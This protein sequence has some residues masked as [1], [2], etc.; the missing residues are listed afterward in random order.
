M[1][2]S[3]ACIMCTTWAHGAS[4]PLGLEL[5]MVLSC[6]VVIG[7]EPGPSARALSALTLQPTAA[8]CPAIAVCKALYLDLF[9]CYS[10][11]YLGSLVD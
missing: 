11:G 7:I 10:I 4:D 8:A 1:S 9:M 5:Q 3:I 2:V 6:P